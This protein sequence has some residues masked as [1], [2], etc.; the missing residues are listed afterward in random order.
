MATTRELLLSEGFKHVAIMRGLPPRSE[1]DFIDRGRSSRPNAV[2]VVFLGES[3]E[4]VGSSKHGIMRRYGDDHMK[5]H[6]GAPH[7]L[8]LGIP[9]R[10]LW[11]E[12][13]KSGP[14]DFLVN[15]YPTE[16]Q[17]KDAE[18]ELQG[19][20]RPPMNQRYERRRS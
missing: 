11:H 18:A 19:R 14:L 17:M 7:K 13:I 6:N 20:L 8:H 4:Y 15:W 16:D 10:A 9:G 3:A 2:Y 1:M 5:W 12:R